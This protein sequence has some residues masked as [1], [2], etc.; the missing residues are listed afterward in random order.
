MT[1]PAATPRPGFTLVELLVAMAVIVALAAIALVVV[2]DVMTQDRTTDAAGTVRQTL[3]IAKARALRDGAPRGV[4]FLVGTDPSNVAKTDGRWATEMQYLE[5]PPPL[6]PAGLN[7][8][9]EFVF[10]LDPGGNLATTP[11][12]GAVGSALRPPQVFYWNLPDPGSMRDFLAGATDANPVRLQA[13]LGDERFELQV[14][15]LGGQGPQA[16]VLTLAATQDFSPV[17]RAL[18][19]GTA[20]RL[21]SF[22]AARPAQP[23]LGEPTIPLPKNVCVDLSESSPG[24]QQLAAGPP[25]TFL[26]YDILFAPTGEVLPTSTAGV[27]NQVFLWVR[28]YTKVADPTVV[29]SPGPPPVYDLGPFQVGGN[30]QVVA[31]KTRSGAVGVFPIQWPQD[32]GTYPAISPGVFD[33]PFGF[34]RRGLQ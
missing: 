34:A 15:G 31:L 11:P 7:E 32:T 33:D 16:R 14:T 2:P 25:Q 8:S 23:L 3:M 21:T 6:V 19:A 1:R 10:S 30:Q 17:L 9:I 4:R 28:D 22:W 27:A 20:V 24:A 29:V 5:Q 12:G 26:D 18:G 13:V